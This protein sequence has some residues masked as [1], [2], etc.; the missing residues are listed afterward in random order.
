VLS[1]F[2]SKGAIMNNVILLG[3]VPVNYSA[4]QQVL[5]EVGWYLAGQVLDVDEVTQSMIEQSRIRAVIIGETYSSG[6]LLKNVRDDHYS[7]G[8]LANDIAYLNTLGVEAIAGGLSCESNRIFGNCRANSI[9]LPPQIIHISV[10]LEALKQKM[11]QVAS[12]IN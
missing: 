9:T 5:A 3:V 1:Y 11:L 7:V 8:R 2:V 4:V 6:G 10:W 12:K